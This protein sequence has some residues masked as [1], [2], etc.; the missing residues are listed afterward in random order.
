MRVIYLIDSPIFYDTD[1]LVS[2]LVIG[3]GNL[4]HK[5]FSKIIIPK[6]LY[7]ELSH[8]NSPP[9]IKNEL[10]QYKKDNFI[11]IKD[12]KITDKEYYVY[13]QIKNGVWREDE[14]CIGKGEAAA[15]ALAIQNDGVIASN[16]LSD[17]EFYIK[18][19]D[20][21]I[22]TSSIILVQALEKNI[23]SE[24]GAEDKWSKM[25]NRKRNLPASS[26]K[27]YYSS[28]YPEDCKKFNVFKLK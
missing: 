26:F 8:P 3:E 17:I 9:I 21:Y 2:F 25:L 20:L 23:I 24:E 13:K 14:K 28:I 6:Q 5:L 11:E 27:H 10:E 1:C 19:N 22:L 4:L 16:N 12:I 7:D 15:L 18:D